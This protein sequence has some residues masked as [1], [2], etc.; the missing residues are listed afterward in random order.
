MTTAT[1][2][3]YFRGITVGLPNAPHFR[4]L[5]DVLLTGPA[6]TRPDLF[7][8]AQRRAEE[9]FDL[10]SDSYATT[11]FDLSPNVLVPLDEPPLPVFWTLA[12]SWHD[13]SGV[14][15]ATSHGDC[16]ALQHDTRSGLLD[17]VRQMTV[18]ENGVPEDHGVLSFTCGPARLG[19]AR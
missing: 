10:R 17:L 7:L 1:D 15:Q 13:G 6:D 14:H 2:N 19:E 18:K 12:V 3:R 4:T 11:W 9:E 5:T 16:L 8:G